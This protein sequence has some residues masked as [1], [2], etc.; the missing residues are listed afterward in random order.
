[1]LMMLNANHNNANNN[2]NKPHL[3]FSKCAVIWEKSDAFSLVL[4]LIIKDF[5]GCLSPLKFYFCRHI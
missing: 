1:M 3:L 4:N 5:I 2:N